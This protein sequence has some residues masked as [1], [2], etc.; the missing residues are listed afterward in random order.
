MTILDTKYAIVTFDWK[1]RQD[2]WHLLGGLMLL[3]AIMLRYVSPEW[4]AAQEWLP[5]LDWQQPETWLR[6]VLHGKL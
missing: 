6:Q 4:I 5:Q 1:S 3:G 2:W